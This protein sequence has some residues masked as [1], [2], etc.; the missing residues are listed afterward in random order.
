[1][2]ELAGKV[3]VV[4]GAGAGI[5]LA[6]AQRLAAAGAAVVLGERDA[7]RLEAA[8][9][10]LHAAGATVVGHV[11]DVGVT[12]DAEALA[13]GALHAHGRID[14]LVCCAGI[15]RYGSVVETSDE[16]WQEVLSTNVTGV[17]N[18]ARACLPAL[19]RQGGA[20]VTVAS[21]QALAAQSGSAAY[22]AS[23][24]AVLMLT[25]AMALDHAAEGVRVN[26]VCPGSVDTPMLRWAAAELA[27]DGDPAELVGA[28]GRGHPLG[29]VAR[30]DEVA[31]AI[32]FLASER[33][34]FI[35]GAELKVDGGLLAGIGV[36]LEG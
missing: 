2:S 28:W 29:R 35:T 27:G 7:T 19:A 1:M 9:A 21:V 33:A 17:F 11:G 10:A 12:A 6:A 4:T 3:A 25:K 14:V 23:K 15:Q 5:G 31:E 13:A 24:G 16:T 36:R 32:L 22:V 8:V 30:P 26:C 20:I 18:A 34:S